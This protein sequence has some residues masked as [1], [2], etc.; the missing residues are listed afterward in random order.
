MT[1]RIIE[2]SH[3]HIG[4]KI[5]VNTPL[6]IQLAYGTYSHNVTLDTN[7]TSSTFHKD[8]FYPLKNTTT[9]NLYQF[10]TSLICEK[11]GVY[12]I[13][14]KNSETDKVIKTIYLNV[15]PQLTL[16]KRTVPVSGLSV[17]T[18]IVRLMGI[19]DEW[20]KHYQTMKQCGYNMIHYTPIQPIGPSGSAYSLLDHVDVENKLFNKNDQKLNKN[21][22]IEKIRKVVNELRDEF[23]IASI[24]DIVLSHIS[25]NSPIVYDHPEI[26][27]TIENYPHLKIGYRFDDLL[28]KCIDDCIDQNYPHGLGIF[29]T[30]HD[31]E[32][33][34]EHF[35]HNYMIPGEF[36]LYY[37]GR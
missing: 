25:S 5:Q 28:H 18:H 17:Q 4:Y 9:E 27:Y 34:V 32:R 31:V 20:K 6:Q 13:R 8:T 29:N 36:W 1:V 14:I 37:V 15:Y 30:E 19:V 21:Q 22:K 23:G 3:N 7:Y 16:G 2:A 33:F 35:K 10:Q 12:Q 11:S 24:V 26:C